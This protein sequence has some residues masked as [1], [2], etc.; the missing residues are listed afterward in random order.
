VDRAKS[1]Q[2]TKHDGIN[3]ASQSRRADVVSKFVNEDTDKEHAD[4][5]DC[6]GAQLVRAVGFEPSQV[7]SER[8]EESEEHVQSH[9]NAAPASEIH[10]PYIAI[11]HT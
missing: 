2:R 10:A 6:R 3:E 11:L 4:A 9:I 5:Q 1:A 7:K 8:G